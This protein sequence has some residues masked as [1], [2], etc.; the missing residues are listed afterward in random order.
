MVLLALG[1]SSDGDGGGESFEI[2]SGP[3][4][5][6]IG[7]ESFTFIAGETDSF[8]SDDE[9]F[10]ASLYA[11][12]ITTACQL[13]PS[14]TKHHLLLNI[15]TKP[16]DYELGLS[17]TATFVL[18]TNSGSENLG[19][20]RGRLVVDEVTADSIRGKAHVVFDA[21]NEVDGVFQVARCP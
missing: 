9:Q 7:G 4:G 18:E 11:D 15:P 19:A 8:L 14:S 1:C 20:T 12:P 2:G 21:A 3:L 10:F 16:G 13:G 5:G 17:L 6:K